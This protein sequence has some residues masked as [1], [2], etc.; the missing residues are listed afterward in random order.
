[1]GRKGRPTD[2]QREQRYAD[3]EALLLRGW[4]RHGERE[5]AKKHDV[6]H[7]AVR[8]WRP[9]VRERLKKRGQSKQTHSANLDE[10]LTRLEELKMLA[11]EKGDVRTARALEW[12][13]NRLLD[14]VPRNRVELNVAGALTVDH[15]QR[16]DVSMLPAAALEALASGASDS[17]IEQL[18][19]GEGPETID[20]EIV[21]DD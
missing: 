19:L 1:M 20:A 8:S 3:A 11:L 6:S 10:A 2:E 7:A 9:R 18:L 14:I 12:D 17:E 16:I 13:R 15:R 5:L 4:T 21:E